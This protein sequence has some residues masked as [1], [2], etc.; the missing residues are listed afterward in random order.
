M[1]GLSARQGTELAG[2]EAGD[3]FPG[4]VQYHE[5]PVDEG[6]PERAIH[7]RACDANLP[8][9]SF[10][11]SNVSRSWRVVNVRPRRN[12]KGFHRD[13]GQPLGSERHHC[14]E[15]A[16][17][18]ELTTLD[19]IQSASSHVLEA[20]TV[21]AHIKLAMNGKQ[22]TKTILGRQHEH[23]P[24]IPAKQTGFGTHAPLTR[25]RCKFP[26]VAAPDQPAWHVLGKIPDLNPMPL[27]GHG[28][29][30]F[31]ATDDDLALVGNTQCSHHP[32]IG[33]GQPTP[34]DAIEFEHAD[35]VGHVDQ[36]VLALNDAA[37]RRRGVLI[38]GNDLLEV[39]G[40]RLR[41]RRLGERYRGRQQ[42]S[43]RQ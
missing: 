42:D 11:A 8:L 17:G 19:D 22:A 15:R 38:V 3:L 13:S 30:E 24:G 34:L 6:Q 37:E 39:P 1:D 28:K 5:V 26:D 4:S 33:Q 40:F 18:I 23:A 29:Q 10:G 21:I 2:L 31:G 43:D 20:Y 16:V 36:A 32:C 41:H 35:V 27:A 25:T 12:L 7:Q 9:Q 14:R